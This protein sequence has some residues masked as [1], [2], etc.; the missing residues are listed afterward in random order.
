MANLSNQRV[1]RETR[2]DAVE[3]SARGGR[4][5]DQRSANK[6]CCYRIGSLE[7]EHEQA[8]HDQSY[9]DFAHL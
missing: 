3:I 5:G 2:E 4:C 9:D 7:K 6:V 8:R 1:E